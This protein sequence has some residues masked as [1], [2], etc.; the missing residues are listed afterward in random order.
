MGGVHGACRCPVERSGARRGRLLRRSLSRDAHRGRR[1]QRCGDL[2]SPASQ[3]ARRRCLVGLALFHAF[4]WWWADRV[5]ALVVAA[6][7]ASEGYE[8]LRGLRVGELD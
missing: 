3:R 7:A 5:A 4:G 6:I 2:R 1:R 8:V